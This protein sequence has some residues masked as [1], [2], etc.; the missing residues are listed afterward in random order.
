[1]HNMDGFFI[2]KLIKTKD[3]KRDPTEGVQKVKKDDQPKENINKKK[4]TK[5]LGKRDRLALK[6]KK[7][8]VVTKAPKEEV[9]KPQ[10]SAPKKIVKPSKPEVENKTK[11]AKKSDEAANLK[12]R[13]TEL[14]KKMIQK[15]NHGK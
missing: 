3:G 5:G 15:K 1:M 8:R 10:P 13:K 14:L 6:G 11:V 9:P 4:S 2:A 12:K 7:P